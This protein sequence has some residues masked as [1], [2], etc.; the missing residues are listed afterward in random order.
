TATLAA[1][2][3]S[4][5][6]PEGCERGSCDKAYAFSFLIRRSC[7]YSGMN[8]LRECRCSLRLADPRHR[9]RR[10][11]V[12]LCLADLARPGVPDPLLGRV[13]RLF[14]PCRLCQAPR[15][16]LADREVRAR[17]LCPEGRAHRLYLASHPC[18][19]FQAHPSHLQG[20]APAR[21]ARRRYIPLGSEV[22][23]ILDPHGYTALRLVQ[24]PSRRHS[25][26]RSLAAQRSSSLPQPPKGS[27]E[28]VGGSQ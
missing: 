2:Q 12:R 7:S 17:L 11:M 4:T 22:L 18:R 27:A 24:P 21:S 28:R 14:H 9:G 23:R 3:P 8:R 25:Q 20:R 15:A 1:R 26:R 5:Q 19:E 13:L 10:W 6:H 16:V